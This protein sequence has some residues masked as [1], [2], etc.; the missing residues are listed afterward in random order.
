MFTEEQKGSVKR[1]RGGGLLPGHDGLLRVKFKRSTKSSTVLHAR[2]ATRAI[3][4]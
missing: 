2:V 4:F 1:R 3:E